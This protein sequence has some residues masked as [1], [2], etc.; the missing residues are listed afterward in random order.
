MGCNIISRFR[1]FRIAPIFVAGGGEVLI[2]LI[3]EFRI[4]YNQGIS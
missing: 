3:K 4:P 1:L 2:L